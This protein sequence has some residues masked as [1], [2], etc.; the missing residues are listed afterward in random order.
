MSGE[1]CPR[2]DCIFNLLGSCHHALRPNPEGCKYYQPPKETRE[3]S[4]RGR[5]HFFADENQ[6]PV[7][8]PV[9]VMLPGTLGVP[10]TLGQI[11]RPM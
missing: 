2:L 11:H 3:A 10:S 5:D 9:L 8:A 1:E 7:A 4:Y 6:P